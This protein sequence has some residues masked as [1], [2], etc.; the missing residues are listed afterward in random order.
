VIQR[1]DIFQIAYI[2]KCKALLVA[3]GRIQCDIHV[4]TNS[5][6]LYDCDIHVG[7]QVLNVYIMYNVHHV[8]PSPI[9]NS[10]VSD[11]SISL[12]LKKLKTHLFH[13]SFPP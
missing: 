13:S 2:F 7:Q 5:E 9:S 11:L 3:I 8:T 6:Y 4:T 10:P 1:I 12:Y